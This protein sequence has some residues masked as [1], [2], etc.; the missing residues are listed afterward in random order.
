MSCVVVGW[1]LIERVILTNSFLLYASVVMY[2]LVLG[3]EN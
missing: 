1:G 3:L 2:M